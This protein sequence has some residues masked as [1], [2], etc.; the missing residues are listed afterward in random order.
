MRDAQSS[1]MGITPDVSLSRHPTVFIAD[2]L[3]ACQ[4]SNGTDCLT[5]TNL[6]SAILSVLPNELRVAVSKDELDPMFHLDQVASLA[7]LE[8]REKSHAEEDVVTT[9]FKLYLVALNATSAS[10][11]SNLLAD[12]DGVTALG[13]AIQAESSLYTTT[14]TRLTSLATTRIVSAA[15][16]DSGPKRRTL[17]TLTPLFTARQIEVVPFGL[18]SS[19]TPQTPLGPNLP[20]VVGER[21]KVLLHGFPHSHHVKLEVVGTI[22][23]SAATMPPAF[24]YYHRKIK[25][26]V[27]DQGKEENMVLWSPGPRFDVGGNY[28]IRATDMTEAGVV[29]MTPVFTIERQP[30]RRVKLQP[31]F[32]SR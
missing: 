31:G 21:Y 29:E 15:D 22:P 18:D 10:M 9:P 16:G 26:H 2:V 19:G 23:S 30:R 12:H 3:V 5:A 27:F 25:T 20:G 8:K 17:S 13:K 4:G 7:A 11:L 28:Y 24:R 14:G 6:R 1:I 32:W